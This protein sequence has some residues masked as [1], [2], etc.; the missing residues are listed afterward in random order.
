MLGELS[1]D[2]V[3]GDDR[4]PEHR[5]QLSET[6]THDGFCRTNQHAIWIEEVTNRASLTQKLGI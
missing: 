3:G 5:V 6:A 4:H 2:D 1:S